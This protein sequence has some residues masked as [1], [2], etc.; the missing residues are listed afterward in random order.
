MAILDTL[1]S[2]LFGGRDKSVGESA[3]KRG[4]DLRSVRRV[5][6]RMRSGFVWNEKLIAPRA[7]VIRDLSVKGARID[8]IGD[9]VKPGI[10]AEGIRL[11][12]NTEK[13]EIQ[14]K[15]AWLKGQSLGLRFESRP[16]PPSRTYR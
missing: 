14:C 3:S 2:A 11:Y 1:T 12:F 6:Q 7:C 15:V 4:E 9:P 10:L 13:H 8:I 16:L 5:P